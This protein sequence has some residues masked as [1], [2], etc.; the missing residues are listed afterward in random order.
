MVQQLDLTMFLE[1]FLLMIGERS[2]RAAKGMV[3]NT[4]DKLVIRKGMVDNCTQIPD[5]SLRLKH[6]CQP[7]STQTFQIYG[8][9]GRLLMLKEAFLSSVYLLILILKYV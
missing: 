2:K 4:K 3:F 9:I 6:S 7:Q 8:F 5:F 1:L